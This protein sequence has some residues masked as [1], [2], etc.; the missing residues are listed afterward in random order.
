MKTTNILLS[1]LTA[2]FLLVIVP[3]H[4]QAPTFTS[5]VSTPADLDVGTISS[6]ETT[7]TIV[8]HAV[9]FYNPATSG[10]SITLSASVDDGSG[11]AFDSYQWNTV[12]SDGTETLIA[13]QTTLILTATA[14]DPGYHKYRVYGV[15]DNGDGTVT[16]QSD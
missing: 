16:C 9:L 1:L 4:A 7:V 13:G 5:P 10:P 11:N 14:L 8:V 15:V 6:T 12:S 3:A 2:V